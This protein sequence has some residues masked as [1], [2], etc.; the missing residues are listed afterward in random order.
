MSENAVGII[1]E[2]FPYEIYAQCVASALGKE[3]S[4]YATQED[5]SS[6][7][8]ELSHPGELSSLEGIGY[9]TGIEEFNCCKNYVSEIPAGI[10]NCK[11]LKSFDICKGYG[12]S[13]I[14]VELF[15]CTE[16]IY[17]RMLMSG[18][19]ELPKELGNLKKLISLNTYDNFN[20]DEGYKQY[21]AD[22][23]LRNN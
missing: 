8:T 7:K 5:L 13:K 10:G 14:P 3:V 21:L 12:V 2:M 18:I 1:N 11:K 19:E 22:E 16:I 6:I 17:M 20:L 23:K 9:L 4:D 15:E